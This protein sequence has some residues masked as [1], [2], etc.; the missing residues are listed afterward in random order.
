[1][2]AG[3]VFLVGPTVYLLSA[4]IDSLGVYLS[5]F[6]ERSLF[7]G[8]IADDK[9]PQWWSNFYWANWLAWA[10]ITALFLGRLG[11]GYTVREFIQTTMLAPSL[12][13]VVW[14]SIFGGFAIYTDQVNNGALKAALDKTGAESVI[15]AM[16][17]YLPF[18]PILVVIFVAL[19]FISFVT[20]SDSN[21]EAIASLCEERTADD[22]RPTSLALKVIWGSMIGGI[23]WFMTAA[24]DIQGIKMMSNLGGI[25]ALFIV[26]GAMVCTWRMMSRVRGADLA[27]TESADADAVAAVSAAPAE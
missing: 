18:A 4:A 11:K 1:M 7:T 24:A 27:R 5:G 16:F 26:I 21:C 20:A 10:P 12:F 23:A 13:A 25:P 3:F 15:Y 17:E 2:L 19:S 22:T 9:W 14:M 8:A 6:V